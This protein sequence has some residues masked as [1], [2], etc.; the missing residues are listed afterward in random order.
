MQA[1]CSLYNTS[2]RQRAREDKTQVKEVKVG[3][4]AKIWREEKVYVCV[5][6]GDTEIYLRS[7]SLCCAQEAAEFNLAWKPE[8]QPPVSSFS[9]PRITPQRAAGWDLWV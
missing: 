5:V 8:P 4:E 2:T 3:A 9:G 7:E 6:N 1:L